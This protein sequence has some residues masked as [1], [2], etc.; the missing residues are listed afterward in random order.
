MGL[1]VGRPRHAYDEL[2]F[3][4]AAG[5]DEV[6]RQLVLTR[7]IEPVSKPGR[8]HVLVGA[9]VSAPSYRT[10]LRRL[11]VSRRIPGAST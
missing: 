10:L 9:G 3:D 4:R 7:I 2:G 6:F 11:P 5:G 8:L 1:P